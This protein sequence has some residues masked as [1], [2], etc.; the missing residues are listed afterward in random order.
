MG[1]VPPHSHMQFHDQRSPNGYNQPSTLPRQHGMNGG[2]G[3]ALPPQPQ[4]F[5]KVS[6]CW[7]SHLHVYVLR[8]VPRY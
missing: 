8:I 6:S 2:G 4:Q 7:L 3:G 1:E 5:D